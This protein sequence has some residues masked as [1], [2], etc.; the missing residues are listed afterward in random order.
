MERGQVDS[1]RPAPAERPRTPRPSRTLAVRPATIAALVIGAF[2]LGLVPM[3]WTAY[4]RGAE[5]DAMQQQLAALQRE[6]LLASAALLAR[7]GEYDRAR[8]AASQFFT[9]LNQHVTTAQMNSGTAPDADALR[10]SLTGRDEIITLLARSDPASAARLADLYMSYTSAL[11]PAT[12]P[13]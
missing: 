12:E 2:L 9:E 3:W 11:P 5:R 8:E 10:A 1:A 4:Q 13:Q 7:Q 6:N